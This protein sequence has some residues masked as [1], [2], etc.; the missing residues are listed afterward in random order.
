MKTTNLHLIL[1]ALLTI[2]SVPALAK[3]EPPLPED[4][5]GILIGR[6]HPELAGIEELYVVITLFDAEPGKNGLVGKELDKL[7]RDRLKNAGITI[8]EDDVDKVNPDIKK[9]L[10][11]RLK[12]KDV[13][14]LRL[15]SANIPE[16]RIDIDML[17]LTDSHLYVFRIQTSLARAVYLAKHPKLGFKADVWKVEPVIQQVFVQN[18][19]AKVT[20]VVLAQVEAFIAAY[21]AANPPGAKSADANN[22]AIV[23]PAVSGRQAKPP[24]K[25]LVA[26]HKFVASKNSKVFHKPNCSSAKRIKPAN[27]VTY[28]TR[29]K[30]TEAGKRPCKRCKP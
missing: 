30:A 4:P 9:V 17:K 14:N 3:V 18:M 11:R 7:V 13:R 6:A 15:R 5:T 19:P 20:D 1:A 22:I 2:L 21:R 27:L 26:E 28:S 8:A 10:L 16:L 25:Q 12:E 23:L 24:V 29:N